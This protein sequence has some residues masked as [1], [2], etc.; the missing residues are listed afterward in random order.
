MTEEQN[1]VTAKLS[2]ALDS[3]TTATLRETF[4]FLQ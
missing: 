3:L 2:E 1:A 4:K